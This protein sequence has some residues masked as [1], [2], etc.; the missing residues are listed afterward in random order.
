MI[1]LIKR[2]WPIILGIVILSIPRMFEKDVYFVNVICSVVATV[3]Y[4]IPICFHENWKLKEELR[5]IDKEQLEKIQ[6]I[7]FISV[8]LLLTL[9]G[10]LF[11][12]EGLIL[13]YAYKNG[14]SIGIVS[15]LASFLVV[16]VFTFFYK[17]RLRTKRENSKS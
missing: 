11:K 4:S 12:I 10:Y 15:I 2:W 5:L 8:L 3:L 16:G 1:K 6:S 13:F 14:F 17:L 7:L 9:I